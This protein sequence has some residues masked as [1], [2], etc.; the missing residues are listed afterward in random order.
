MQINKINSQSFGMPILKYG[1][2]DRE[3]EDLKE[4]KKTINP[5]SS[6]EFKNMVK[7]KLK[8]L[9]RID[10]NS[11]GYDID[12]GFALP[13]MDTYKG[14]PLQSYL[15]TIPHSSPETM[16]SVKLTSIYPFIGTNDLKLISEIVDEVK[17]ENLEK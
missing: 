17:K 10:R 7:T 2:L 16:C 4:L 6:E 9:N 14:G 11:I 1:R 3:R 8:Y 15:I 13:D 12:V 5:Y